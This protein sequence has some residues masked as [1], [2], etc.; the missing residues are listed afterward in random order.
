MA[1]S[2]LI[3]EI[4][5]DEGFRAKVYLCSEGFPTIGYGTKLPLSD[6]EKGFLK[7]EFNITKEEADTLLKLRLEQSIR[8]LNQLRGTIIETLSESRREVV[9][10]MVYQMGSKRANEFYKMWKALELKDYKTAADEMKKSRWYKQTPDR[11][12]KL[13]EKMRNG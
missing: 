13:M 3:R 2:D 11:V 8:E 12:E 9:Y 10:N 4:K 6:E 7:D 5:A 1:Y